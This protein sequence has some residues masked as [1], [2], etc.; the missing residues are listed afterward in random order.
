MAFG[1]HYAKHGHLHDHHCEKHGGYSGICHS[2][3]ADVRKAANQ[4]MLVEGF[5]T[6]QRVKAL[7]ADN[8]ALKKFARHVIQV[9]CWATEDYVDG[10]DVQEMAEKLGFISPHIV[11][12]GDDVDRSLF[13]DGD[14]F[15]RFTDMLKE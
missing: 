11:K 1:D 5:Q 10:G 3:A 15:Y 12:P 6:K 2:C 14:T 9:E 7:E 13:E 8:A 4:A